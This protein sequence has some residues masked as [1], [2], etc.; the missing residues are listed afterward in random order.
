MFTFYFLSRC[1]IQHAILLTVLVRQA[2]HRI[3]LALRISSSMPRAAC[4]A[5]CTET[6]ARVNWMS[7]TGMWLREPRSRSACNNNKSVTNYSP[8][9]RYAKSCRVFLYIQHIHPGYKCLM[10]SRT[11]HLSKYECF[12]FGAVLFIHLKGFPFAPSPVPGFKPRQC[13]SKG[14]SLVSAFSQ[15]NNLTSVDSIFDLGPNIIFL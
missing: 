2:W 4:T 11:P 3:F 9:F 7:A 12:G 13:A 6:I 1:A 5:Q 15:S 10:L 14:S 8:H